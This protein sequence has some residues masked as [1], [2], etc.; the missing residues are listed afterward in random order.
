LG[1]LALIVGCSAKHTEESPIDSALAL[2]TFDTAWNIIY[3]THFDTTFNGVD[4]LA[5]KDELRPRA[6]AATT[7]EE[8]RGVIRNMLG[9]LGQSHFALIPREVADTLDPSQGEVGEQVGTTGLELRLIEDEMV[10]THVDE[11]GA[12]AVVGIQ[13]GWVLLAVNDDRVADLLDQVRAGE[14]RYSTE[15]EVWARVEARLQGAPGTTHRLVL[16]DE[17]DREQ[18]LEL[19]LQPD[20]SEPVKFGNLPTFFTRA[21]SDRVSSE[22]LGVEVGVIWFNFW[23]APLTRQIDEAVEE[24]RDLDGIV[25]DLR[26]NGGGLGA[27]V[28]GVAGHFLNDRVVLGTLRTRVTTLEIKANPRRVTND[29]R[30]VE[31]Y[32]GPVAILID[33]LTGSASEM[34]AGGMQAVGRARVFG[35]TSAGAV[36]PARMDRLPNDDVLYHAFG[37]FTTAAGD[38][39]EGRGVIP[40]EP[41][42]PTRE[43]ILTGRDAPL[44]AAVRWIAA[45][46]A[47]AASGSEND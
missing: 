11:G 44:E 42:T 43:G 10:V 5:L 38:M 39:L 12:G 34:F 27:M 2:E 31:P 24:F 7:R 40:D 41:V 33:E 29:G 25:V 1:V 16:L 21:R 32:S 17:A 18:E 23:M 37:D 14:T 47:A 28:S 46:R 8:L 15:L 4:W 20:E 36:L 45:E 13:P 9:R 22:E 19:V 3:E 35:A 30:R 26:G 6:E